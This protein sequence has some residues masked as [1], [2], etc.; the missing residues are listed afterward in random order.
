MGRSHR[1]R[2]TRQQQPKT[3]IRDMPL[4]VPDVDDDT[5]EISQEDIEF[6]Q[7]HL[8]IVA[9][10]NAMESVIGG[11][12]SNANMPNKRK[13]VEEEEEYE[14]ATRKF[15]PEMD[16]IEK[17][18]LPIK[19]KDGTW[20]VQIERQ[21]RQE[22]ESCDEE[23]MPSDKVDDDAESYESEHFEEFGVSEGAPEPKKASDKKQERSFE[24]KRDEIG[25]TAASI[26]EDPEA[27]H[28][29]LKSLRSFLSDSD[30]RIVKLAMLTQV[31]VYRDI[32]P[33]YRIRQL[34]D[35]ERSTKVSKDVMKVRM[36]EEGLLSNYQAFLQALE[37]VATQ[38]AP[39]PQKPQKPGTDAAQQQPQKKK[40][41]EDY[42]V[43]MVAI[44][45]MCQ[46]MLA[47]RHFN[48]AVNLLTSIITRTILR[49]DAERVQKFA[50][51]RDT[52]ALLCCDTLERVFED[53]ESGE[54]S[55]E[56]VKLVSKLVK[57]KSRKITPRL[58]DTL[59]KLHL[60][61][62][63][64]S[65]SKKKG[66]SMD[67]KA[68]FKKAGKH[69]T[70]RQKK[71]LD[72]QKAVDE[73]LKEAEAT[74]DQEERLVTHQESL[75]YVFVI[76]FRVLKHASTSP[77]LRPV[78]KGIAHFGHLISIDYFHDIVGTIRSILANEAHN[79]KLDVLD[80]FECIRCAF[81]LLSGHAEVLSIDLSDYFDYAQTQL[82]L[83]PEFLSR[84]SALNS[85]SATVEM[86]LVDAIVKVVEVM[87]LKRG[88]QAMLPSRSI[89]IIKQLSS[90]STCLNN[91]QPILMLLDVI[92]RLLLKSPVRVWSELLFVDEERAVGGI[93]SIWELNV[94]SKHVDVRVRAFPIE[95]ARLAESRQ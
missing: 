87:F 51:S 76:Y 77:L 46:L 83:V 91:T 53:D 12:S 22:A 39:K 32:I 49:L 37:N 78:L 81:T 25:A 17:E 59:L 44:K 41:K 62:D 74:V 63:M 40:R 58:L 21:T 68:L 92:K 50:L 89:Q 29:R 55:L 24:S 20:K 6:F 93:E 9:A 70:R 34:S 11:P 79:G 60:S 64:D 30:A 15:D 33:G 75:K 90:I 42:S 4:T 88:A 5:V 80:V 27:H 52:V 48:Y 57:E 19:A 47:A 1:N 18:K 2:T 10:S 65:K 45:S 61:A 35:K 72:I 16:V 84:Q 85:K 95:I 26:I 73:E 71:Q 43:L 66:K 31:A 3:L 36:F 86:Q 23:D 56:A 69:L 67:K 94:L 38:H 13:R 8:P 7:E 28:N 54:I 82:G 14:R